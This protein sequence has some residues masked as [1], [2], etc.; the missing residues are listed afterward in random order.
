[1]RT[2][3]PSDQTAHPPNAPPLLLN[4]PPSL[5]NETLTPQRPTL[6]PQ[7]PPHS[8]MT[9]PHSLMTPAH[10][11]VSEAWGNVVCVY[12]PLDM[13]LVCHWASVPIQP[14]ADS[15]AGRHRVPL[16]QSFFGMIGRGS[17]SQP[18]NLRGDA[19]TTRP[20]SWNCCHYSIVKYT[21]EWMLTHWHIYI[22]L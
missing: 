16:L 12:A 21:S 19:L 20:L 8:P 6:T 11:P 9:P 18:S 14:D 1:M 5:P 10:S 7:W 13:K 17:N 15:Q 4:D 2:A 22:L 3:Q